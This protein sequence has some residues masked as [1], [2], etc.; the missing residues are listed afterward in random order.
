MAFHPHSKLFRVSSRNWPIASRIAPDLPGSENQS[1][2]RGQ[3]TYTFDALADGHRRVRRIAMDLHRYALYIFDYGRAYRPAAGDEAPPRVTA[4][5]RRTAT[6]ISRDSATN[7]GPGS[8]WREPSEANREVLPC[9][10]LTGGD[11]RI[12]VRTGAEPTL[13]SPDGISNQHSHMARPGAEISSL[14]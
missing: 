14:T 7:G 1:P 5:I 12:S 3:F 8:Y 6:R 4:I 2:S 10:A 9:V 11:P 13:L